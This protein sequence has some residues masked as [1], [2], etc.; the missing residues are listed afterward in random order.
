MYWNNI[1]NGTYQARDPSTG[2]YQKVQ[3]PIVNNEYE[4]RIFC[5]IVRAMFCHNL[6]IVRPENMDE[7]DRQQ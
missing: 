2:S 4:K 5:K 1:F 7:L 3:R 6:Q